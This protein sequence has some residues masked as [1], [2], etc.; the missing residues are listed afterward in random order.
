[1]LDLL[2]A[3]GW[4]MPLIVVCSVIALTITIE[5]YFAL[6]KGKIAPQHLLA[7]V[8]RDLKQGE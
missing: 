4:V 6:D 3:G 2:I 7:T 8:G 5:R 1:M